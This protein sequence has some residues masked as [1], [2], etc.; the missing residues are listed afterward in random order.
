MRIISLDIGTVSLGLCSYDSSNGKYDFGIYNLR[1]LVK[2]KKHC[3]GLLPP[4]GARVSF[5]TRES[6]F[7]TRTYV[8]SSSGRS[9]PP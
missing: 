8:Y 9:R 2:L 6:C 4:D 5:T 7:K 1:A 3:K